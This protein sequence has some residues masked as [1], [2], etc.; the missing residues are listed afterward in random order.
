MLQAI[1]IY[2]VAGRNAM[3]GIDKNIKLVWKSENLIKNIKFHTEYTC[4]KYMYN[5][6][7]TWDKSI[8]PFIWVLIFWFQVQLE[9]SE[10]QPILFLLSVLRKVEIS[11][12]FQSFV[13]DKCVV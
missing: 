4:T 3:T 2:P 13:N 8:A 7:T 11:R 1:D 5:V 9:L 10:Q 6:L 12:F